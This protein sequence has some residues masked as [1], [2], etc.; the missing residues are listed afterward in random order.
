VVIL[1]NEEII[2]YQME[3]L[4][5]KLGVTVRFENIN[6]EESTSTG[7]LCCV[8]GEYVIIVHS[9]ATVKEKIMV[10]IEALRHFDL[11]D[12]Y[13]K[14]VIRQLVEGNEE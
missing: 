13:I 7:G 8:R 6:M 14:P 5:Q 9:R 11:G 3:E 10:M 4:A 1:L 12:I 2:L